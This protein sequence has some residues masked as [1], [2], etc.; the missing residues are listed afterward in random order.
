M[1]LNSSGSGWGSECRTQGVEFRV[2]GVHGSGGV[3]FMGA[4]ISNWGAVAEKEC[5]CM[6][7]CLE[8]GI[9]GREEVC[10]CG[11]ERESSG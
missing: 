11:K 4:L 6:C 10:V 8:L 5:V 2:K 1:E 3:W 9:K 7:V